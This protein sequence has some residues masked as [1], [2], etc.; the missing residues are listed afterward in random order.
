[1]KSFLGKEVK[2]FDKDEIIVFNE[3][4]SF[5]SIFKDIESGWN[6]LEN[7]LHTQRK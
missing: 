6:G 4:T 1:M 2:D 3:D 7:F 5:P